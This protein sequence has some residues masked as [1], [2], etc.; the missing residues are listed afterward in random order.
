[1]LVRVGPYEKQ[2][3]FLGLYLIALH[4]YQTPNK[5]INSVFGIF[6]IQFLIGLVCMDV[7][8]YLLLLLLFILASVSPV[9]P[10][11]G[12]SRGAAG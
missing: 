9:W 4:V 11:G 7:L 10:S 6:P 12:R 1:M 8:Y 2:D 3:G 5:F